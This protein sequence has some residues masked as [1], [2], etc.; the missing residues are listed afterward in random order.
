MCNS[1]SKS[2]FWLLEIDLYDDKSDKTNLISQKKCFFTRHINGHC[3]FLSKFVGEIIGAILTEW[4]N[5]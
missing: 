3:I 2:I 1:E 5:A 4:L